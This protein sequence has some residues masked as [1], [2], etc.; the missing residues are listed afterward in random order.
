MYV[1]T[2]NEGNMINWSLR[3]GVDGIITDAVVASREKAE[4]WDGKK[5]EAIRLGQRVRVWM[6]SMAVVLLGW[7][8]EWKYLAPVKRVQSR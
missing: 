3:M 5:K 1:W 2:V 4:N 7:I 6:L 8:F